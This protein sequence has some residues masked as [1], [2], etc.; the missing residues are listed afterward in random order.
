MAGRALQ[1]AAPPRALTARRV[2]SA[3]LVALRRRLRGARADAVLELV[4]LSPALG[5]LLRAW[6]LLHASASS[7]AAH[8]AAPALL[9]ATADAL[10]HRPASPD[11]AQTVVHLALD[12]LARAVRADTSEPPLT[13][14][15]ARQPP[16][17]RDAALLTPLTPFAR[18]LPRLTASGGRS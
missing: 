16:R 9:A 8:A 5:E 1:R 11:E 10:A 7:D 4:R 14:R 3:A 6:E 13:A 15:A 18:P 2:P 12:G 17:R